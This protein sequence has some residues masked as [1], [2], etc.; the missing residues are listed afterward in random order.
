MAV[1]MIEI[2]GKLQK[3]YKVFYNIEILLY[4]ETYIWWI[5]PA[6]LLYVHQVRDNILI[7]TAV[8]YKTT[9]NHCN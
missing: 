8:F 3:N 4:K 7:R 1:R 2:I 9:V 6:S 5:V